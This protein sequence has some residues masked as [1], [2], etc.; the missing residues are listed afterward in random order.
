LVKTPL[1]TAAELEAAFALLLPE[2]EARVLAA[3]W[4]AS[5][6]G[7]PG[8]VDADGRY[9]YPRPW[10]HVRPPAPGDD[11]EDAPEW[12]T[13]E[14]VRRD[15]ALFA[16][17]SDAETVSWLGPRLDDTHLSLAALISD[18]LY[19]RMRAARFMSRRS[20]ARNRLQL[21]RAVRAYRNAREWPPAV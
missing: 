18:E 12:H 17:W 8:D 11:D 1:W 20:A 10:G 3:E 2:A 16:S 15:E 7:E 6:A 4:F 19:E 5:F 21:T 14:Q 13:P 9:V